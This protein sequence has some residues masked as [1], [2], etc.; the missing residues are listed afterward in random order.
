MSTSSTSTLGLTLGFFHHFVELHGGR[1]AFQG[2]STKDVCMKFVK[3]FTASSQL[4]LVDHVLRNDPESDLYVQPATWFV[5]HAWN[6]MF[7]DVVDALRDFFD[8][9]GVDSD[10]VAVWFCMF[11]NNQHLVQGQVRFEFWVDSFQ[12][13]LTSIGNVVMVL[14]PW[15][16]PTTLTRAWCVF[17]IYVAIVTDA[18]F[19]VAMAKA[20]K[21][22]F[23]DDIKDDSA[24]YKM[25]G[26]INSEEARTA[27]P[28]DRDNIF[29]ALQQ[30]NLFFAD[31]D[32]ML[33]NVLEAWML[34]T[35]QSQVN[36]SIGDDK[37][38]WLAAMGAMNIDK[39]LYDEAKVCFT[40]AVHLYRQPTGRTDDPRIWKAMARIGEIHVNTHQPRT[41][42]EPIFQKAMAHQTALL[43]ESH[44]DTLT[45]ILLLGQAYVVGGDIALGLSIL[46]KCFQL[47]DGVYSDERPL[48]L[49]LMN[50]IGMAYSYLNQLHEAHA[51]RQRCYD[52]AVRALGKT[53][54]LACFSAFNLCTSQLKLGEYIPA[55][56]LM[57]DV[58]ESRRRKHGATH[59]DT[60]FAYIRLGHLY[61][62]Q[63]KYDTASRIL[64]E[65][66]D[67]RSILSST[68]QLQCRLGLGMLYL[69]NGEF[70]SA[71]QHL[72][73]VHQEYKLMLSATHP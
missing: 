71:E 31:L 16:N 22:A 33:F 73:S 69:S 53:N 61:V 59:D 37:A 46:T 12:R 57:Q 34:R 62:F 1:Y 18:R 58:Y 65:S 55:T 19:E 8:D 47:S 70:E 43:G 27:V 50:M 5:S 13:A 26:T 9:L 41:V 42:W 24:F 29:H 15:Y 54:P 14:S 21:E 4:S 35:I 44:Y 30:A 25:L 20:Q 36:V 11:N 63:G 17:E 52:R 39:R 23:L 28:S 67:A 68:T 64:Y 3:P 48:I 38:Q 51:W 49:G 72:S 6:Y 40:D 56:L 45:T 32:R 60:W 66:D 7:L 10:S 2:L